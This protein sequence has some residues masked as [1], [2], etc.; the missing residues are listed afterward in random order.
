MRKT[1]L[2][3]LLLSQSLLYGQQQI[4]SGTVSDAG[5]NAP[6]PNVSVRIKGT[7]RGT[8]TNPSGTFSISAS[9]GEVLQFTFIGYTS[10]ERVVGNDNNI[11]VS[12]ASSGN[13]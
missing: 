11:T 12:L 7:T 10:Q 4:I 1:L 13:Q 9:R 6:L 5:N 3:F 2:F 8:Q